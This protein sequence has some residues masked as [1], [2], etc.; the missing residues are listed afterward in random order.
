VIEILYHN[1]F[2]A[3]FC[4]IILVIY[5]FLSFLVLFPEAAQQVGF[6]QSLGLCADFQF[7]A[8]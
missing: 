4:I 7:P 5:P 1:F 2:Q 6:T 8:K 3:I